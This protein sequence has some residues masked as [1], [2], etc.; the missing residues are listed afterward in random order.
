MKDCEQ[1]YKTADLGSCCDI[2]FAALP[3]SEM[4]V[5][6]FEKETIVCVSVQEFNKVSDLRCGLS[7]YTLRPE[8]IRAKPLKQGVSR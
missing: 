3:F 5:S 2:R 6:F 8:R 4:Q 7:S 1:K